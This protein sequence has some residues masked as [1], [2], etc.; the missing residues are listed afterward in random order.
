MCGRAIV[1]AFPASAVLQ[2]LSFRPD[3][4]DCIQ[5]EWRMQKPLL[6]SLEAAGFSRR[7]AV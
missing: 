1:V 2:Q 4:L 6:D 3:P 5:P 7:P